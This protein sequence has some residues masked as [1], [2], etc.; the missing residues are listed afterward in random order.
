ME[1]IKKIAFVLMVVMSFEHLHE[2]LSERFDY[3]HVRQTVRQ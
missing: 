2:P 3:T 1:L